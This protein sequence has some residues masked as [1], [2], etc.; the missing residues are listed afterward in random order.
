MKEKLTYFVVLLLISI[1]TYSQLNVALTATASH[2]GGSVT[3]GTLANNYYANLYNDN[4]ISGCTADAPGEWGWVAQNG[5]I[6]F[7]WPTAVTFNQIR[8]LKANRPMSSATFE[9]WNGSSYVTF[10]NYSNTTTCDHSVAFSPI[11]TTRFRINNAY[12]PNINPNHREIQIL[13]SCVPMPS[14]PIAFNNGPR[15]P[16]SSAT[17]SASGLAPGGNYLNL[18]GNGNGSSYISTVSNTFTIDFWVN[19][20]QTRVSTTQSNSGA[21]G[22]NTGHRWVIYPWHGGVPANNRAGAGVS[23]G[24]NGISVGE[25]ADSYMPTT[26]VWN[27]TITGWTHVAIVYTNRVPSLYVNGAW[28]A[29]GVVSGKTTVYPSI[30]S[31]ASASYGAYYGGLDNVRYWNRA[32]SAAEI[33]AVRNYEVTPA[34][35]TGLTMQYKLNGNQNDFLGSS[36]TWGTTGTFAA[37]NYYTYTW[38]GPGTLPA[39]STNETQT[40]TLPNTLGPWAYSVTATQGTGCSSSNIGRTMVFSRNSTPP[41]ETMLSNPGTCNGSAVTL[42]VNNP[43]RNGGEIDRSTWTVG[44][45]AVSGFNLNGLANENFRINA[46]NPWGNSAVVWEARPVNVTVAS[47]YGLG[48]WNTPSFP[49]DNSKLYRFSVWV[50]RSVIGD[51]SFYLGLR[52]YQGASNTGVVTLSTGTVNTNPYFWIGNQTVF[53]Q[54]E[55]V[56][57]VGHVYP[58]TH[59]GTT[60]HPQSGRYS[61]NGDVQATSNDYKWL[62]TTTHAVHRAYLYYSQNASTRQQFLYPRVDILDGSEPSIQDLLNGFDQ[63]G[64]LT[65][66]ASF[67]WFSGSCGGTSVGS[68]NSITVTPTT[69][70]RYFV[71]A[72]DACGNSVCKE[73]TVVIGP[74]PT[75]PTITADG[76]TSICAGNS[77]ELK[78]RS[79][80]AGG[81]LRFNGTSDYVDLG[82]PADLKVTKNLTIEMWLKPTAFGVRRNPISKAYGG[83]YTFTLESNGTINCYFGL[84]GSNTEPYKSFNSVLP[85]TLN[86][87]NH[88]AFVREDNTLRWY[89]NGVLTSSGIGGVAPV[90]YTYPTPFIGSQS[91]N[92][93]I[94][95]NGYAG[96]YAGEMDEVRIWKVARTASEISSNM[97]RLINPNTTDLVGYWRFDEPSGN[98]VLDASG[99]SQTGTM[100]S[101]TTRITNSMAPIKPTYTW[102]PTS[103]LTTLNDSMVLVTPPTTTTYSVVATTPQGC[104]SASASQTITLPATATALSNNN[105]SA[106]CIVRN[107]NWIHFQHSSGRLIA[108]VQANYSNP[109]TT[110]TA[111]SY[112]AGSP[113]SIA[114]CQNPTNGSL[115]KAT[116]QRSWVMNASP[117]IAGNVTVRLYFS[118]SE[119]TNLSTAANSNSN[120]D[121]NVNTRADLQLTKYSGSNQDGIFGDNTTCG[122]SGT[123]PSPVISRHSQSGNGATSFGSVSNSQYVEFVL[124]SFS[125]LW[126]HGGA[127]VSPLPVE[128]MYFVGQC[129][130]NAT[131]LTWSTLSEQ[132]SAFFIV[133]KSKDGITWEYVDRLSGAGNSNSQL[134]YQLQDM[135]ANNENYYRLIQQDLDGTKEVLASI[136]VAC[137]KEKENTMLLYPNP[138]SEQVTIDIGAI[139]NYG[140]S[141]VRVIDATGRTIF[142]DNI[143]IKE[144]MQ[145]IFLDVSDY[146]TGTYFVQLS[147]SEFVL[148]TQKLIIRK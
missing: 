105:E 78:A 24:T 56:L 19:P 120:P 104:N 7:V 100:M 109:N 63:N 140:A 118:N 135:N 66:G 126:L 49:I 86:Q 12:S 64:G 48:G 106:T 47:N 127:N 10:Y 43:S 112:V 139:K 26:L 122:W 98:A 3:S 99:F 116:L 129:E 107:N 82:N 62:P 29:T 30:G 74:T 121:D 20:T 1:K 101:A 92:D 16:G 115:N 18:S 113:G 76:S 72:Q 28:V 11:T 17:L 2:G 71:R 44:S 133:E 51:G 15:C 53:N 94:L 119:F 124:N 93:L 80:A 83:E 138:A 6:E 39:A 142:L 42:S 70:T 32:L 40:V 34:S 96:F 87:W 85:I 90:S 111:T 148:P 13:S 52:G 95:G 77:V 37:A 25:H 61:I 89:V 27:G 147:S 134:I 41:L 4:Y 22:V 45:G 79:S 54:D 143:E 137:E 55:W 75:T 91:S 97:N 35:I 36:T 146:V 50:K 23:V 69:N 31:G 68:G 88:I 67:R 130:N 84:A 131:R 57:V 145:T 102:T 5:W 144:G 65:S 9:Y 60:N 110:I 117:A 14:P 58:Y 108:S 59:T 132:N 33:Q 128:L 46:T 38:S 103:N 123:H 21:V 81:A 141:L 8:L 114:D 136:F 125:E 73:A